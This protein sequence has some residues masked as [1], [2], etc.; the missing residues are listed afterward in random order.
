LEYL[1]ARVEV[2][3]TWEIISENFNISAKESLSYSE[4]KKHK[5]WLDDG[6]SKLF[7]QRKQAKLQWLRNPGEINGDNLN[8]WV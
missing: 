3:S 7:N 1:N 4:L 2:N 6:C 8:R 5:P